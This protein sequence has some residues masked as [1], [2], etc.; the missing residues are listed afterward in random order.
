VATPSAHTARPGTD[1]RFA[2]GAVPAGQY[3]LKVWH[4]RGGLLD[5]P[6]SLPADAAS[7]LAIQLDA[8]SFRFVQHK[9]K[10][11]GSYTTSGSERY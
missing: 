7:P 10:F 2:F 4:E 11:G 1:G 3:V 6:L 8:R 5:R 9:N